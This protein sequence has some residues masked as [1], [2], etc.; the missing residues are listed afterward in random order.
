MLAPVPSLISIAL[1]DSLSFIPLCAVFLVVLL[2]GPRPAPF[3]FSSAGISPSG[4]PR[5]PQVPSSKR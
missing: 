3:W 1:L 5:A 4:A 2:A